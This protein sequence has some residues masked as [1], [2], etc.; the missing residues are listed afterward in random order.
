M[1]SSAKL[2][3]ECW[4]RG[5]ILPL[6]PAIEDE[7]QLDSALNLRNDFMSIDDDDLIPL[8]G[9]IQA[10]IDAYRAASDVSHLLNAELPEHYAQALQIIPY[11]LI[12]NIFVLVL[13][14]ALI[15][16]AFSKT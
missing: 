11:A 6:L 2:L 1:Y 10:S 14:I 7:H 8:I 15:V 13:N 5:E 12:L 3:T 4:H 16:V 9:A